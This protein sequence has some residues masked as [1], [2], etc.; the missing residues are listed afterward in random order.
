MDEHDRTGGGQIDHS[1]GYHI[2]DTEEG[3]ERKVYLK[4]VWFIK[5]R[6]PCLEKS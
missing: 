4:H 2:H 5:G 3:V 1:K 6:S